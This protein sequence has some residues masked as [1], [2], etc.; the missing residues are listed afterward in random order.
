MKKHA[1]E[2]YF[3]NRRKYFTYEHVWTLLKDELKW[4]MNYSLTCSSKRTKNNE[5]GART[6]SDTNVE[7]D[8]DDDEVCLMGQNV[9]FP[10]QLITLI[11]SGKYKKHAKLKEGLNW[12]T[13]LLGM[14]EYTA[15]QKSPNQ[16]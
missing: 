11:N 10:M 15:P 6:S 16:N 9:G 1:H 5:S 13:L 14:A 7:A 8:P 12:F 4:R 2:L 3:Q